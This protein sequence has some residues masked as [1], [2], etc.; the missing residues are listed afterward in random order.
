VED[1]SGRKSISKERKYKIKGE[2]SLLIVP[3][4]AEFDLG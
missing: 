2:K 1:Q 4:S 3:S